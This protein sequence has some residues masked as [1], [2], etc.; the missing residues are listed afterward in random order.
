LEE[1]FPFPFFQI[2]RKE[3]SQRFK[4]EGQRD[5]GIFWKELWGKEKVGEFKVSQQPTLKLGFPRAPFGGFGFGGKKP[6]LI[7]GPFYLGRKF[8]PKREGRIGGRNF[9]GIT[10]RKGFS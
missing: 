2:P 3:F 10:P 4:K 8:F 9:G 1:D 6:P 5:L 7:L